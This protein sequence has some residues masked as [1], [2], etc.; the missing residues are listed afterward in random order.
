MTARRG[1]DTGFSL[2][3]SIVAIA[4]L[5]IAV[6]AI[7]GALGTAASTT[8]L[9]ARQADADAALRSGAEAIKSQPYVACP[10]VPAYSTAGTTLAPGMTVSLSSV[11][12]WNGAT[13]VAACPASDGGFQ[14]VTLQADAAGGTFVRTLEFIKRRP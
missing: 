7:V 5:G 12:H 6:V 11:E 8:G 10:G 14:R 1:S 3:E 4:I 13:F 9:Q 2:V